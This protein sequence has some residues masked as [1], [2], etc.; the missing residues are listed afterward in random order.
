M[1]LFGVP[2]WGSTI[3]EAM[4][5]V[6][7]QPYDFVDVAGFDQPGPARARLIEVNPL[8]QVPALLLADGTVMTETAAIALHLADI[9]PEAPLAPPPGAPERPRFLRW[10]VWMVAN[11]YPTFTYGDYPAR[12][13][14]DA[15]GLV[16]ST[17][18][19]RKQLWRQFEPEVGAPHV[20]GAR[21]SA[22]DIYVAA[23][24]HWR[25]RREWFDAQTPRV[26]AAADA[27]LA[28]PAIARV[29]ARNFRG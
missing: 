24:V 11:V 16:E 3:A 28:N 1:T 26:A 9:V 17:L 8:A 13:S 27:A 7:G 19:W 21:L 20:L 29:M 6:A 22:L 15:A 2:G 12:W 18:A 25:P 10:L 4:L 23:M 14:K 5:E